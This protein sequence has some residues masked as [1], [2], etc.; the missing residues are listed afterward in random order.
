M[1]EQ[2]NAKMM[3]LL[4]ASHSLKAEQTALIRKLDMDLHEL[5]QRQGAVTEALTALI[6]P[7]IWREHPN[8]RRGTKAAQARVYKM[9]ANMAL[10]LER[11]M[12]RSVLE[13]SVV[14]SSLVPVSIVESN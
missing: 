12:E 1:A 5:R 10:R 6:A 9:A 13:S 14:E 11:E 8:W 7:R 2:N 3:E 4:A